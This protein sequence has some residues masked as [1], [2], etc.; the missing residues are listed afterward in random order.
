MVGH[1][2]FNP[3]SRDENNTFSLHYSIPLGICFGA[4]GSDNLKFGVLPCE[5]TAAAINSS[6]KNATKHSWES[7]IV[8]DGENPEHILL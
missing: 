4:H 6:N 8:R 7:D 2:F 3:S 5:N 1:A